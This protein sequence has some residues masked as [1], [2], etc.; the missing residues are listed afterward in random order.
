MKTA[1]RRA[2][3]LHKET[4]KLNSQFNNYERLNKVSG[5][6][7]QVI[8]VSY[9]DEIYFNRYNWL[10]Y[11]NGKG[12]DSN[13]YIIRLEKDKPQITNG[14][15]SEMK[16][17]N[18]FTNLKRKIK[19]LNKQIEQYENATLHKDEDNIYL[20]GKA[21]KKSRCIISKY[22]NKLHSDT[23]FTIKKVG[24]TCFNMAYNGTYITATHR[25][26]ILADGVF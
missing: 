3:K 8:N 18:A 25:G 26:N 21:I 20:K 17:L 24:E 9:R 5:C 16:Q 15:D 4:Q 22:L 11:V 2:S 12:Y 7:K 1:R 19:T 13:K 6:Q 14:L 10:W 23:N